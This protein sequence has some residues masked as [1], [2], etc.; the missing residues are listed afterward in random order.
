[1]V[2]ATAEEVLDVRE[3]RTEPSALK[4]LD[5][6]RRVF[7]GTSGP[8]DPPAEGSLD[9]VPSA[10]VLCRLDCRGLEDLGE[11]PPPSL[12]LEVEWR[13]GFVDPSPPASLLSD[14]A[15]RLPFESTKHFLC[16]QRKKKN[17]Q[18][19]QSLT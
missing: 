3:E 8:S 2:V 11:S 5:F 16:F 1:M 4:S 14:L 19:T 15:A 18:T 17:V 13:L 12:S 6:F 10:E 9:L 7:L